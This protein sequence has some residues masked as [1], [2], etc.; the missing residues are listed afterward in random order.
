[1]AQ[2][3]S[4]PGPKRVVIDKLEP[5]VEGGAF[6]FKRVIGDRIRFRAHVFADSHDLLQVE[7]RLR[8]AGTRRWKVLPMF[9][10][11][12]DEFAADF[13]PPEVALYEYE[14]AGCLDHFQTWYDG[15]LKKVES[16]T[17]VEVELLIGAELLAAASV[18]AEGE[19]RDRLQQW[20]AFLGDTERDLVQRIQLGR[21]TG[22]NALARAYPDRSL[23][24]TSARALFL[25]ERE[26]AAFST[27]YEYFPRSCRNDGK[28]H[29]TFG[30]AQSRFPEIARMG[31]NVVYLPPIHPIGRLHRKGR[32]NSLQAE[33]E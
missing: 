32:N 5:T 7:L 26:R 13:D 12:N 15:F 17:E 11:G 16:G 31:F 3:S 6:P 14:V 2:L 9:S 8:R 21:D 23:E 4:W 22:V 20:S 33:E 19:D 29:A 24:V 18:R 1:M 25:I 30:D 28:T 27:W 10:L